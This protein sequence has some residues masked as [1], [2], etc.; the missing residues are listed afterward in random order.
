MLPAEQ[1]IHP[2]KHVSLLKTWVADILGRGG[3]MSA[4]DTDKI[5]NATLSLQSRHVNDPS[6]LVKD[7][8]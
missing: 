8:D 7:L 5:L 2:R 1:R 4:A 6:N 3:N